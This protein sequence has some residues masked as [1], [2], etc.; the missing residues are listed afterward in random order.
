MA[1]SRVRPLWSNLAILLVGCGGPSTD[2]NAPTS[3]GGLLLN[4][5]VTTCPDGGTVDAGQAAVSTCVPAQHRNFATDVQP[6][7]GAC[8]GEICHDFAAKGGV[9]LA[10]GSLSAECCDRRALIAPGFPERSYL[11]D[12]LRGQDL[13]ADS[14]SMPLD[15]PPLSAADIEII[16]DWICEGAPINQ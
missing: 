1:R 14:R 12:K 3:D 6:I 7:F 11:L 2:H 16:S 15:K 10:I 8:S 4:V 5:P 9:A 13:C